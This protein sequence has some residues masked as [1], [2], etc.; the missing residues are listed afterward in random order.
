MERAV[1]ERKSAANGQRR[2]QRPIAAC[3]RLPSRWA[4][5]YRLKKEDK[6]D[7]AD[8]EASGF[9]GAGCGAAGAA[10]TGSSRFDERFEE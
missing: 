4:A 6:V 3:K 7:V 9:A 10:G 2:S 8:A 5:S 1:N